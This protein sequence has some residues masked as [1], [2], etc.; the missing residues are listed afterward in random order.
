MRSMVQDGALMPF[1]ELGQET[2]Q[3]YVRISDNTIH[4][5]KVTGKQDKIL[6]IFHVIFNV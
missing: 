5:Y 3:M 6:V 4:H 1:T 2:A